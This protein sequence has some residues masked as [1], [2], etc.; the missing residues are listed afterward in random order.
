MRHR[1]SGVIDAEAQLM[2]VPDH[3]SAPRGPLTLERASALRERLV[4]RDERALEELIVLATPWLLGVAQ[5]MLS[6][7]DEAEEVVL[8]AFRI[9][10]DRVGTL[11]D[12]QPGLMAWLLRIVR[13]RAI[14]RLR[15]RK[16][17]G[18]R[19]ERAQ[20]SGVLGE[21]HDDP[22]TPNEAAQPGWHVHESVH[23]A[24]RDLPED[25]RM[26]VQLA[27]FSGLTHSEIAAQLAIPVGTVKTRLRLAYGRLRQAL[28]PLKDWI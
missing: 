14:D 1:I 16:R 11:A 28:A 15:A 22:V 18:L 5:R 17:H 6:D 19:I 2:K 27:Y 8:E 12:D 23:A 7:A 24:L 10:W 9:L 4:A 13:N 20:R 26:A 3:S 25:Q 21:E